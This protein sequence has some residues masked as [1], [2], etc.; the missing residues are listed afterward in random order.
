MR[1]QW[2][3]PLLLCLPALHG[4]AAPENA[5]LFAFVQI[6]DTHLHDDAWIAEQRAQGVQ[7]GGYR[8]YLTTPG[9]FRACLEW[10][11]RQPAVAFVVLTGDIVETATPARYA[12]LAG[13]IAD[14]RV[15]WMLVPGN[16]DY[17]L[18]RLLPADRSRGG[19][20]FAFSCGGLWFVGFQTFN[21][22]GMSSLISR[23]AMEGVAAFLERHRAAPV[24][25]LTHSPLVSRAGG[26]DSWEVP[27]NARQMW[28]IIGRGGNVVAV[29]CGHDH[30]LWGRTDHGVFHACAQGFCEALGVPLYSFLLWEA[31]PERI[32]GTVHHVDDRGEVRRAKLPPLE[33]PL[34][35]QF[36]LGSAPAA[37]GD[38]KVEPLAKPDAS[39]LEAW[40]G[41]DWVFAPGFA[42]PPAWREDLLLLPGRTAKPV[43]LLELEGPK[44]PPPD[45][46]GRAWWDPAYA[47]SADW[48]AAALPAVRW[49]PKQPRDG[50]R[51]VWVRLAFELDEKTLAMLRC[52]AL[53]SMVYRTPVLYLNGHAVPAGGST[54]SYW[55]GSALVP[56]AWLQAGA[57]LL[58]IGLTTS[59]WGGYKLDV[60]LAAEQHQPSARAAAPPPAAPGNRGD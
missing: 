51:T 35:P 60:E 21:P 47:E 37:T 17:G 41:A 14:L 38:L 20:D 27:A 55:D 7:E 28:E 52:C 59:G 32:V 34:P 40:F 5:P 8:N 25:F 4:R 22:P 1:R 6:S 10:I 24:L 56:A 12:A 53:R 2:L 39:R 29:L 50:H 19:V 42:L 18:E 58:A 9:R 30:S 13:R 48:Q 36:R 26:L 49:D 45:A 23:D 33:I 44:P 57:N 31:F 16:H 46:A 15:P 3:L 43:R 54:G 11:N